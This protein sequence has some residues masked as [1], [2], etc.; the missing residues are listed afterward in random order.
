LK[1]DFPNMRVKVHSFIR[2]LA[3]TVPF[4]DATNIIDFF[5]HLNKEQIIAIVTQNNF[6]IIR[7]IIK[8]V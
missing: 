3:A 7:E 5:E 6:N 8:F 1:V 2:D 4:R